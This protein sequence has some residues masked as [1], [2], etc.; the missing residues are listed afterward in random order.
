MQSREDQL[1]E[2]AGKYCF[3][4]R[5]EKASSTGPIFERAKYTLVYDINGKIVRKIDKPYEPVPTTTEDM[6]RYVDGFGNLSEESKSLVVKIAKMPRVKTITEKMI[7]DDAGNLWIETNELREEK[8]NLFRAYDIF[9]EDGI[10]VCKVWLER[11]PGLIKGEHMY[12]LE[13]D[14]ETDYRSLKR[15]QVIWSN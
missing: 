14:E 13:R 5:K 11:A 2:W 4:L 1:I 7:V 15:Y 3:R 8:D 9:N 10:Y 6:K 12:R